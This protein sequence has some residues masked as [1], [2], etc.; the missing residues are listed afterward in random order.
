[1]IDV[2]LYQ[3]VKHLTIFDVLLAVFVVLALLA[4]RRRSLIVW[5]CVAAPL[6]TTLS[7][8]L[9]RLGSALYV[10]HR[11]YTAIHFGPLDPLA[12][13][14]P[15][16][17]S[18]SFPSGHS[19]LTAIIVSCVFL[20][21]RRWSIPFVVLGLLDDWIRVG[22]SAHRA[23]DIVGGWMFVGI[24]TALAIP[25]GAVLAAMVLPALT[26]A[27]PQSRRLR[28]K[29]R[30]RLEQFVELLGRRGRAANP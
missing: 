3:A 25:V 20:L 12:P 22:V 27:G 26:N 1:M 9:S 15:H 29:G 19:V 11:T 16:S 24:G 21:S 4:Q 5:W 6:M 7:V 10:D 28:R 13:L 18:N 2:L 23:I 14:F 8:V 17:A 30:A